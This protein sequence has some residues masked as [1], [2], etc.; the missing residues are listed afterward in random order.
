MYEHAVRHWLCRS[1]EEMREALRG[2]LH[3]GQ[4]EMLQ[5]G[6]HGAGGKNREALAEI[7]RGERCCR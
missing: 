1:V 4:S 7:K 3:Y 5:E 2:P 6:W